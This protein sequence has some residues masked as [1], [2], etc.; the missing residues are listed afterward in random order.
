MKIYMVRATINK[1]TLAGCT[2]YLQTQ[3]LQQSHAQP[4]AAKR[5]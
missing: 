3:I 2:W 4:S 1:L 5:A